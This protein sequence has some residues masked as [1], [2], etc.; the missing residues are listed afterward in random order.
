MKLLIDDELVNSEL[1]DVTT[2]EL[3]VGGELVDVTMELLVE[4]LGDSELVD[5]TMMELLV[6]LLAAGELVE[7]VVE[8]LIEGEAVDVTSI[9]LLVDDEAVDTTDVDTVE[10]K[11]LIDD[12]AIDRA[13]FELLVGDEVVDVEAVDLV[14]VEVPVDTGLLGVELILEVTE[15]GPLVDC[16]ALEILIVVE[17]A[18]VDEI[19]ETSVV[20]RLLDDVWELALVVMKLDAA[21]PEVSEEL[22][23]L[24][25]GLLLLVLD[26]V[27]LFCEVVRDTG[28]DTELDELF[29]ED[30]DDEEVILVASVTLVVPFV[31]ATK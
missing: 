26:A 23:L 13:E 22:T 16:G 5:V 19:L 27:L 1:F 9:E 8:L 28:V 3:L 18:C 29:D 15:I 7:L 14:E 25:L 6:E 31:Q 12:E 4:L 30:I 10:V 20:S 21:G 24:L 17:A 2:V 11:L